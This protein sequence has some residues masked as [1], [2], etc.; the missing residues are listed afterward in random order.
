[1]KKALFEA[2]MSEEE[3]QVVRQ[4][5]SRLKQIGEQDVMYVTPLSVGQESSVSIAK[6]P[7]EK[8]I[9]YVSLLAEQLSGSKR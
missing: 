4:A 7:I 6:T 8:S 2:G 1:M 5:I 3:S 9:P